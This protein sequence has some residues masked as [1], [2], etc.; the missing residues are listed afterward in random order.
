MKILAI[1]DVTSPGGLE[2]LKNRLWNIRK[3]YGVDLCIVNGENASV[4]SGIT[5]EGAQTLFHSGADVITGGNHTLRGRGILDVLE[6]EKNLL[7]PLNFP[8][9][10][11]GYGY[12]I[13]DAAGYR[14]LV[15]N[16]LG[17]AMMEPVPDN[18]YPKIDRILKNEEGRYDIAVMDF[19]AEATGEKCALAYAYDGAISVVFG[20][21]TH[22]PTADATILPNGTGYI[23]DLGMCGETGGVLGM[24]P[25]EVVRRMRT[26]LPGKFTPAS[27]KVRADGVLFTVDPESKR[28]KKIE[29]I[30]F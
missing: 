29:R 21:H 2:H 1:G 26:R 9:E 5:P 10:V 13:A 14:V 7:R 18:P 22:V 17:Q 24:D 4:I 16:A 6:S 25:A 28:V 30:A 8:D 11:P 3:L 23:S 15:M 19:H 20:T 27:G 12:T